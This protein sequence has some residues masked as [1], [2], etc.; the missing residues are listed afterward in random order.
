MT[1]I[2]PWG[3]IAKLKADITT[4][5]KENRTLYSEIT[6]LKLELSKFDHDGDG[7]VGGS[8]PKPKRKPAGG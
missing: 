1:K 7:H 4:L 2:W 5:D 8:K 6:K 3:R